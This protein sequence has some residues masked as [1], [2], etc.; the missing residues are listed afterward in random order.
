[1]T[2]FCRTEMLIGNDA[3]VCL[4]KSSVAVFGL[5]GVGSYAAEAFARAGI[6]HLTLVDDDV[7][8]ESNVNRQLYALSSTVGQ[9]KTAVAAARIADINPACAVDARMTRFDE[10]TAC[11]FDF[12]SY[13][14]VVDAIDTVTSKLLLVRLCK[15]AGTPIISCMGTGNKLDASAFRVADIS[16]TSV[17]PLARV[18]RRE[19][20]AIGI[21]HLKTVYSAE[22]P[23]T[24]TTQSKQ[25]FK[26]QT[27]GSISFVPPVA[28]FIM[29]GEVI[30]DLIGQNIR[31]KIRDGKRAWQNTEHIQSDKL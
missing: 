24:P 7:I 12:A 29:A 15:S 27:P 30:N 6:G 3:L 17:C 31:A 1:M 18:M 10:S 16:E 21:T 23:L 9:A 4:N 5:G 13:D 22:Q 26:R 2:K 8:A 20:K 14:Y 19:L 28:G 25:T 11:K